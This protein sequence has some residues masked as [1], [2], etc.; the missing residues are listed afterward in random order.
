MHQ[1]SR[2][3]PESVSVSSTTTG[4]NAGKEVSP[5]KQTKTVYAGKEVSPEKQTNTVSP[6]TVTTMPLSVITKN[7]NASAQTS[8]LTFKQ[9]V[10]LTCDISTTVSNNQNLC[11]GSD[12]KTHI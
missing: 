2:L 1:R 6:E 3:S 12:F 11:K 7:L 8:K 9:S 4:W 5:E 10:N